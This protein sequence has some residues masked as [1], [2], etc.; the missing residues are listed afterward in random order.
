MNAEE[1][2]K[3]YGPGEFINDESFQNWILNPDGE[4]NAYW[5]RFLSE[6]PEKRV[7][8]DMAMRLLNAIEFREDWPQD[9]RVER[10]LQQALVRINDPGYKKVV[11]T[12]FKKERP[13]YRNLWVAAAL[14]LFLTA[15]G[16]FLSSRKPGSDLEINERPTEAGQKDIPPGG[17][18]AVLTLSDGRKLVLDTADRGALAKQGNVTIINLEGQLSYNREG[19]NSGEVLYNTI[20]TPRGGQYQLVLADGTRVW[21][22][23]ASSLRFPTAFS[24]RERKV[25]LTGE[26]YFEVAANKELPFLV[27]KDRSEVQVLGTHFN[28]NAYD[29]E[30]DIKVTLLEGAVQVSNAA[31]V[32]NLK[33]GQQAQMA[34]DIQVVEDVSI[35]N[36]LAWK[37]GWFE[38]EAADL[39]SIMRQVNRWYDVDIVYEGQ[40]TEEKFGG[41][42]SKNL[43]LSSILQMLKSNGAADFKLEDRKLIVRPLF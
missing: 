2:Y 41:R 6:N 24:G 38:F 26:G 21:L 14:L 7:A 35:D 10:Y 32:R 1:N 25:E 28:I 5:E 18:R 22:N 3:D 27:V 16:Y 13:W 17:N 34:K 23:A 39:S 37:N 8:I 29:D 30:R 15:A 4:S 19:S 36:V 12:D 9:E 11:R 31:S 43:P 42:I 33:P 20:T 40:R